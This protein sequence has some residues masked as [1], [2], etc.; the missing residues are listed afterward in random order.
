MNVT[1]PCLTPQRINELRGDELPPEE[2]A[3]IEEHLGQCA[4]CQELLDNSAANQVEWRDLRES[5][6]SGRRGADHAWPGEADAEPGESSS[7]E[8]ILELLGP[9]DDPR[10]LGRIGTYEIVGVLGRGGMG[11]VFKGF[12]AALNRYVAIKLLLPH[13]ATTGAARS[14]SPARA[15]AAAAIVDEHVMAIHGVAEWQGIPYLVMPYTRGI[16]LQKRLAE[17]GPLELARDSA[18]WHASGQALAAAHA[19]GLVHR[20]VKPANI[21]LADGVERVTLMDFG[22]ARAIDDA[23]LTRTGVLAG[24]P[25][26]MSPEQARG[27]RSTPRSDLFSLGSVLYATCTGRAPVSARIELRCAAP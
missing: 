22:L 10:M 4:H 8:Q 7:L 18:D 26:Y 25:Q 11:V 17:Q 24:T 5:L 2:L 20:D 9:T 3:Q 14:D 19:Q 21:L 12:D 1:S 16:S 13:M 6:A 23:S 15:Q 27:K